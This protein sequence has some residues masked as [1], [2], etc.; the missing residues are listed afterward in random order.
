MGA[1]PILR[2]VYGIYIQNYVALFPESEMW[3]GF[4]SR[5]LIFGIKCFRIIL[6][7]CEL[8][9]KWLVQLEFTGEISDRFLV[10]HS[11]YFLLILFILQFV[12]L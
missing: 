6:S 7:L 5:A 3:A 1:G 8:V 10:G 9:A 4:H 12:V 11:V 2:N